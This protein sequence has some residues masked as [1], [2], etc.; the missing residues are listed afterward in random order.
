MTKWQVRGVLALAVA[1]V[2]ACANADAGD[3]PRIFEG[4]EAFYATLPDPLFKAEDARKR[5]PSGLGE[6]AGD[7]WKWTAQGKPHVLQ[8]TGPDAVI[9]GRRFPASRAQRFEGEDLAPA[10][11]RSATVYANDDAVCVEG[12]PGSASGTA[13]RHVRVTLITQPYGAAA[14]RFE[15]PSLFASCQGLTRIEQGIGFHRVSYRWP[16]SAPAPEGVTFDAF[17]LK[18]ETFV[19]LQQSVT[20]TFVE[21]DNVY[22]F[23]TR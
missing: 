6:P 2:T 21:T 13:V 9:D 20:A 14:K 1:G 17:A 7:F 16:K 11:G 3:A 12:V 10:L 5:S 15:L 22:R 19:P 23:T 4:Y 8:L 18:G